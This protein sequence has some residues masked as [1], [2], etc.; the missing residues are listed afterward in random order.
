MA[1]SLPLAA[2]PGSREPSCFDLLALPQLPSEQQPAERARLCAFYARSCRA[3]QGQ[4]ACT[5]L[6][7]ETCRARI[8]RCGEPRGHA[9][10]RSWGETLFLVVWV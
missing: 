2:I 7:E 1:A 4:A 6:A 8:R 5:S 3:P 10:T 9:R